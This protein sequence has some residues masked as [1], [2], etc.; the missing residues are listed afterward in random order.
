MLGVVRFLAQFLC[1]SAA[2]NRLTV[3]GTVTQLRQPARGSWPRGIKA[4]NHPSAVS[5]ATQTDRSTDLPIKQSTMAFKVLRICDFVSKALSS[6]SNNQQRRASMRDNEI[7]LRARFPLAIDVLSREFSTIRRIHF[8]YF[9]RSKKILRFDRIQPGTRIA[10]QFTH[11][12]LAFESGTH[13]CA[14]DFD[15]PTRA[16]RKC[17]FRQPPE[18][19]SA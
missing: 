5:F 13:V 12:A 17:R 16:I 15:N 4:E 11:S 14:F 3:E 2:A 1:H 8:A 6:S 7:S 19:V 10:L 18:N 9:L